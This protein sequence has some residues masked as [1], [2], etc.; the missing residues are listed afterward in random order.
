MAA[1]RYD[2]LPIGST[3]RR[4]HEGEM[5]EK[6]ADVPQA[7]VKTLFH[8]YSPRW[9][10]EAIHRLLDRGHIEETFGGHEIDDVY[11]ITEAGRRELLWHRE[12]ARRQAAAA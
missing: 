4:R 6:L 9:A 1:K 7:S 8:G 5:L 10:T 12:Q 3:A 11:R 2:P